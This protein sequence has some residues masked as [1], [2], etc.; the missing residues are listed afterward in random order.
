MS[1]SARVPHGAINRWRSQEDTPPLYKVG[2]SRRENENWIENGPF[3]P[4]K[5]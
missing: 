1:N 5:A 4:I 2:Y 3:V